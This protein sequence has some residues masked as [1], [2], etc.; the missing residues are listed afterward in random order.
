M[1]PQYFDKTI[2]HY[3]PDKISYR[4]YVFDRRLFSSSAQTVKNV[5]RKVYQVPR[6]RNQSKKNMEAENSVRRLNYNIGRGNS[7]QVFF[8]YSTKAR[9]SPTYLYTAIEDC[10]MQ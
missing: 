9:P 8:D 3:R 7:T 1:E 6:S 5:E 2:S 10:Y 4:Y